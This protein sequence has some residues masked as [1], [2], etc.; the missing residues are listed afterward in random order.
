V[1]LLFKRER[2]RERVEREREREREETMAWAIS[3]SKQRREAWV[4]RVRMSTHLT[5]P[6]CNR[7]RL[8]SLLPRCAFAVLFP[9]AT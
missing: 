4:G 3:T 5:P 6:A 8:G 7:T 9:A 1:V 2:E